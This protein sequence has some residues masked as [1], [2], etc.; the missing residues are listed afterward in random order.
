[1]VLKKNDLQY[2]CNKELNQ[3]I[4]RVYTPK[5]LLIIHIYGGGGNIIPV[6]INFKHLEDFFPCD[7]DSLVSVCSMDLHP[8]Y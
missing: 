1:M 3:G 2:V 4:Y 5:P 6:S 7:S 8:N